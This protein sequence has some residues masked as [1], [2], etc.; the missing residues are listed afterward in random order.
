M[1]MRIVCFALNAVRA[2]LVLN[3]VCVLLAWAGV[4]ASNTIA[5]TAYRQLIGQTEVHVYATDVSGQLWR[6]L[7]RPHGKYAAGQDAQGWVPVR[8]YPHEQIRPL[9]VPE[10]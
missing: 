9:V 1:G 3:I 2:L 8:E 10:D 4:F 7:K 5:D 6:R